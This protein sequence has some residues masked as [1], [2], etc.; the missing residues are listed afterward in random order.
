MKFLVTINNLGDIK[1]GATFDGFLFSL[2]N[3]A[4]GFDYSFK[5]EEV[6]TLISE[7]KNYTKE[8]YL[9]L[10]DLYKDHDFLILKEALTKFDI[11]KLAGIFV[12]DLGLIEFFK[13]Y[14]YSKVII[15]I[16]QLIK[17]VSD[18]NFFKKDALGVFIS[19]SLKY[20]E[21]LQLIKKAKINSYLT[22]YGD[23]V[24][25]NS[26]RKLIT[27]YHE[28]YKIKLDSNK[29]YE[30][31]EGLRKGLFYPIKENPRGTIIMNHEKIDLRDKYRELKKTR[32][33]YL[34]I[35]TFNTSLEEAIKIR[36][37]LK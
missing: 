7:A 6:N 24:I 32:L 26:I 21:K 30:L 4:K 33:N 9:V 13:E 28:H 12:S 35:N 37:E 18:F 11:N 34:V 27:N 23:E 5:P 8:L 2:E 10:N 14:N 19:S 20:S 3:L 22:I 31:E 29:T 25:F 1:K 36:K 16:E 17:S 15:N